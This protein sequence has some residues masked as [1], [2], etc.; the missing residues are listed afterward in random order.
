MLYIVGLGN[1]GERYSL[2]RH[3]VG[4]LFLDHLCNSCAFRAGRG[5]YAYAEHELGLLFKPLTYMNLSGIAVRQ[6]VEHF[7]VS[8]DRLIVVYDDVD[9]PLG[10]VRFRLKGSAGSHNGMKSVIYYLQT[11]E[12]PRVRIGIGRPKDMSL[13]DWV[14]SKFSEKELDVLYRIFPSIVEGLRS[15]LEG[16]VD[17]ALNIINS[18]KEVAI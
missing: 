16:N 13:K 4:W 17:E 14:L 6:I 5:E 2:T 15:F 1:K 18:I 10:R 9:I 3:N 12:I 8:L 7:N 11:Q